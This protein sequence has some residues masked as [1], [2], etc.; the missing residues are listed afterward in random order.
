M[1]DHRRFA[2]RVEGV[3]GARVGGVD[4]GRS[5]GWLVDVTDV[6][7]VSPARDAGCCARSRG[8]RRCSCVVC[9]V[10]V[11]FVVRR[12]WC[13]SFVVRRRQ[14]YNGAAIIVV[15]TIV[16]AH[17]V[18]AGTSEWEDE[19]GFRCARA[20]GVWGVTGAEAARV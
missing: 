14:R 16:I 19:G 12:S 7:T 1:G 10:F 18:D 8:R 5:V 11:V 3:G 13:S 2:S 15:T 6:T 4:V 17:G 9:V 20:R